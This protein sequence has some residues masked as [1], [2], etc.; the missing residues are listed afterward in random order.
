MKMHGLKTWPDF[1]EAIVDGRKTFELRVN[2][3]GFQ[4]G[5][6]LHLREWDPRKLANS[7]TGRTFL[8][9]VTY[10]L[11][12]AKEGYRE[13]WVIMA[14]KPAPPRTEQAVAPS[15]PQSS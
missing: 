3:R 2:D 7:Y 13:P 6:Q 1:F 10:I 15:V 14:I 9:E 11:P 12:V 5:D 8:V 4:T